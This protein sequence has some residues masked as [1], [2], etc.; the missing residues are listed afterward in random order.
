MTKRKPNAP[1]SSETSRP[2]A[3]AKSPASAGKT[4]K[5]HQGSRVPSPAAIRETIEQIAIA[6]ILAFLFRTFEAE[7]FVIP[8]GS[9]A[10]TL[11]GRHKDLVCPKCGYPYRLN[12]SEEVDSLTG[13]SRGTQIQY[14]VC[15]Q[16]RWTAYLGSGNP[17]SEE[18]DSYTGDRIL[19]DKFA[20]EW[21]DP[22]RWDVAV[23]KFPGEAKT[24]Y[25]KRVV[26]LPGETVRVDRGDLFIKRS[27]ESEFKIARKAPEKLAA[28]LRNVYDSDYVAKELVDRGWP[29][30]WQAVDARAAGAWQSSDD[31]RVLRV[32]GTAQSAWVRYYHF[33][34][35][36][37]QWQP[38]MPPGT[39][40]PQLITD[41]NAY[42]TGSPTLE[43]SQSLDNQG[44][45]W[46]G[47]LALE[48]QVTS[49]S[50]SGTITLELV[51]GGR[52]FTCRIDLATG[53]ALLGID[54]LAE[55]KPS[56]AT[57]L[58][59]IG[60]HRV[61][62]SNVDRQL[63]LWVDRR[64]VGFD[65]PTTYA[66]LGNNRP[67]PADLSPAGIGSQKA[68][69]EVR[70]LKVLRDVYYIAAR[71]NRMIDYQAS[72]GQYLGGPEDLAALMSE[73]RRWGIFDQMATSEFTMGPGQF[74][75]LGDNS[76]HSKD[77]RLWGS[78]HIEHYVKREL[79][80]GRA[81]YVY[82]PHAWTLHVNVLGLKIPIPFVPNIPRMRF[83]R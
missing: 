46:V 1:Q 71:E 20:Y 17:A 66:D 10:T 21:D 63:I 47:D 43:G 12:A 44:W 80:T 16:C 19:V 78:E 52:R 14:G 67:Q 53:K 11:M 74:F 81:L 56:A 42:N 31:H 32:D 29:L 38:N 9:M 54:G 57:A 37:S 24:N 33:L 65:S 25:I 15:P 18:Y 77:G 2:S 76:A 35:S 68:A 39:P 58:R 69:L 55:F 23:F 26:G 22:Q 6:L 28:M 79:L 73:P 59:G 8:T 13:A 70:H 61:R 36:Y 83:V 45:H 75:V 34:P 62:F 72:F 48:C 4:E 64:V 51:R 49:S 50:E 60:T 27:G 41:F 7:A 3:Q 30:R 82:W 5:S 40:R